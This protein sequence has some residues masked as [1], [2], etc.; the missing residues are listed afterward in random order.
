MCLEIEKTQCYVFFA[1]NFPSFLFIVFFPLVQ[2][3]ETV[4]SDW[5]HHIPGLITTERGG[6][7]L[8]KQFSLIN[9]IAAPPT[10]HLSHEMVS[11]IS[12]TG[13]RVPWYG[14]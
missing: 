13:V 6:G 10:S 5:T 1:P 12:V 11:L 8:C 14:S 3:T 4:D 2:W 9:S 7:I